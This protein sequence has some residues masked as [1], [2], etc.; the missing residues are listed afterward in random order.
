MSN[1]LVFNQYYSGFAIS[2]H[3]CLL[4]LLV[5]NCL[6]LKLINSEL[7]TSFM[8]VESDFARSNM[9]KETRC[10]LVIKYGFIGTSQAQQFLNIFSVS[11]KGQKSEKS[12][13]STSLK[14]FYQSSSFLQNFVLYPALIIFLVF[15][16]VV[17]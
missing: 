13:F 7:I 1:S 10:H 16:L 15:L 8:N 12:L 14:T 4:L 5:E 3:F 17:K 9:S 2:I 6:H 11:W